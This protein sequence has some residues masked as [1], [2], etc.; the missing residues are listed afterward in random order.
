LNVAEA[1][2][3]EPEESTGDLSTA[4]GGIAVMQQPE[5]PRA[6]KHVRI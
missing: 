3:P 2:L 6:Q 5:L 4:L 1:T